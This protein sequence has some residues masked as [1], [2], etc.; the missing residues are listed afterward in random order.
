VC[1]VGKAQNKKFVIAYMF[2]LLKWMVLFSSSLFM[3]RFPFFF[4]G[5]SSTLR[6]SGP[7]LLNLCWPIWN[8]D[9]LGSHRNLPIS[10]MFRDH[11]IFWTISKLSTFGNLPEPYLALSV[12]YWRACAVKATFRTVARLLGEIPPIPGLF[13]GQFFMTIGFPWRQTLLS[14][15]LSNCILGY[16]PN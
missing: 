5:F 15:I 7:K 1:R 3:V 13:L 2:I 11:H 10:E 9:W 12:R 16:I 14:A 8:G 6:N 4:S